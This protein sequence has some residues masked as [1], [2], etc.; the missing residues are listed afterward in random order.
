M[1]LTELPP[2]EPDER[3]PVVRRRRLASWEDRISTPMAVAVFALW[4]VA[5]PVG[6]ALEPA[7][8]DPN[9]PLPWYGALLVYAFLSSLLLAAA[10]LVVRQ[11][12]G[13]VASVV[14][15]SILL[16]D[17]VACPV[18]GHHGYG[19]WWLGELALSLALVAVS[20]V[21]VIGTARPKTP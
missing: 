5:I 21:A 6:L 15:A 1:A 2:I 18:T 20:A 3:R 14:A 10:G 16:F 9:A 12:V 4:A 8:A 17:T 19:T 13:L 7:P 11:R